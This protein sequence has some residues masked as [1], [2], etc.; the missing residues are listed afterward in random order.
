MLY[1]IQSDSIRLGFALGTCAFFSIALG[2]VTNAKRVDIF[3]CSAA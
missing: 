3:S 2:L 1:Y